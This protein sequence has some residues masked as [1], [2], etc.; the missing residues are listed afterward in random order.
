MIALFRNRPH[1]AELQDDVPF[2][3]DAECRGEAGV[4]A[5]L[6]VAVRIARVDGLAEGIVE[7]FDQDEQL[8]LQPFEIGGGLAE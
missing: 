4:P 2:P 5:D 7:A 8:C 3:V 1:A 6:V